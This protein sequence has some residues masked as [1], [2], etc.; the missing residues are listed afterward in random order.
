MSDVVTPYLLQ[1]TAQQSIGNFDLVARGDSRAPND[2][3]LHLSGIAHIKIW[4]HSKETFIALYA[5][6]FLE[7]QSAFGSAVIFP[8][9]AKQ[10]SSLDVGISDDQWNALLQCRWSRPQVMLELSVVAGTDHPPDDIVPS[11]YWVKT[12]TLTL[13]EPG[14][15]K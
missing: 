15:A 12:F 9:G 13:C 5:D 11:Q 4:G 6:K 1:F 14:R 8:E 7:Q 3:D 10:P 2:R